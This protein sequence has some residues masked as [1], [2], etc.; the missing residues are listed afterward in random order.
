MPGRTG[1]TSTPQR[2][3]GRRQPRDRLDARARRRRAG[4][5]GA[6][7]LLVERADGERSSAPAR[8][9]RRLG[10][11]VEVAQDHRRLGQD[12]ERVAGR[13]QL[14]DDAARQP[15]AALGRLVGVGVR[16]H[17]DE[18]AAP[19]RARQLGA[20]PLDGVD[21][22]HDAALEVAA[23]VEAEVLVGRPG[24]AVGAGV[25]AAAVGVDRVAE[26][27][28][29]RLGHRADDAPRAHVQVLDRAAAR[30][31]R[32]RRRA[33]NRVGWPPSSSARRQRRAVAALL[34]VVLY[35]TC[36]RVGGE[37]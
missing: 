20:Q 9:T 25:R 22:D 8:A 11:Q 24:E 27:Q 4:L 30:A 32:E 29:R 15:V 14:A 36:V 19:A 31:G 13:R 2:D 3:A 5:G 26:R 16:A 1:A 35:R 37:P 33:R 7:D 34:M 10:Q 28:R 6:P 18:L 21:L 23:R 12:R 17:G